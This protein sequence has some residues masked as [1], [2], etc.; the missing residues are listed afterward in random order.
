MRI[1]AACISLALFVQYALAVP[2]LRCGTVTDALDGG[3]AATMLNIAPGKTSSMG[4]TGYQVVWLN[5]SASSQPTDQEV[6]NFIEACDAIDKTIGEYDFVQYDQAVAASCPG[7]V[8][9]RCSHPHCTTAFG[10]GEDICIGSYQGS[11]GATKHT[12][13][14]FN[15]GSHTCKRA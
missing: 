2:S 11:N 6:K 4:Q 13:L 3:H 9:Y 12:F 15:S 1:P 5:F 10:N 8:R 7:G 14:C